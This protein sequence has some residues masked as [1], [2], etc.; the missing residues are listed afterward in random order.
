MQAS[1]IPNKFPIPF[2]NAA[3]SGFIRAVPAASQQG[4][5]PGAAS[6]TDGFP[7]LCFQ[8]VGAGGIPPSGQDFNGLLSLLTSW[9]RWQAAGAT[10][11][12]DPT[13]AAAIGG[14]PKGAVVAN[15]STVGSFWINLVDGNSTNPD[16]G[17]A[18]WF[19]YAVNSSNSISVIH[20][21]QDVGTADNIQVN[22]LTPSITSYTTGSVFS[23]DV[24]YANA[25]TT[26]KLQVGSLGQITIVRAD[27]TACQPGDLVPGAYTLL[28]YTGSNFQINGLSTNTAP[29]SNSQAFTS[30]GTFTVPA[31]VY[32]LK[33]VTVWGAGGGGGGSSGTNSSSSGGGGGGYAKAYAVACVP[34]QT[35]T[36][37]VGAGGVG[38]TGPAYGSD[39]GTSTFGSTSPVS[40]T[41]GG[42]GSYNSVNV[43]GAGGVGSGGQ[44][45]V[46]GTTAG[47]SFAVGSTPGGG[48]GGAA[49]FGGSTPGLNFFSNGDYG[50]FPGGGANG[51]SCTS[52]SATGGTGGN[53]LITIV[54]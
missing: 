21:G 30:S 14:Y 19:S 45:N 23:I 27:G 24:A 39:G 13:F 15:V 32:H 26:P 44:V 1:Q 52:G 5:T 42:G 22:V 50:N 40:A 36:V 47:I 29:A 11:T 33:E 48:L 6:L 35:I 25:T 10:V 43:P 20:S 53:G 28:T 31:G 46:T 12:Y 2:A 16:T 38:G 34:G 8:P 4:I 3:G 17:G 49:P 9:A 41:G 7:P 54:F 37:T 18:N 51:G